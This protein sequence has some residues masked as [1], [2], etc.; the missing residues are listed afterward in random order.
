MTIALK[1]Q[2]QEMTMP[3]WDDVRQAAIARNLSS[4]VSFD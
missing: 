1:I 4:P 2:F 3:E